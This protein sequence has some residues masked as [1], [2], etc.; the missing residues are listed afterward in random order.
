MVIQDKENVNAGEEL[1]CRICF[2]NFST[3]QNI[4]V[5]MAKDHVGPR[6]CASCGKN[7]QSV[8]N[9]NRHMREFHDRQTRNI[10]KV[11]S[12]TLTCDLCDKSFARIEALK[13]HRTRMHGEKNECKICGKVYSRYFALRRHLRVVHEAPKRADSDEVSML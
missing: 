5:H 7:F 12:K 10:A 1:K 4:K 6:G 8:F 9:L 11:A 13:G 2:K 3:E